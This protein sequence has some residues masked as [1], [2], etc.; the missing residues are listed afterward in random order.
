MAD[1]EEVCFG[2]IVTYQAMMVTLNGKVGRE[3]SEGGLGV[4]DWIVGW[5]KDGSQS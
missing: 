1:Y 5:N 3:R 4:R 2:S